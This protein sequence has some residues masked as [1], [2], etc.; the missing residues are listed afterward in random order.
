MLM[1]VALYRWSQTRQP[2][3][4]LLLI[5]IALEL[6]AMYFQHVMM[7]APCVMCI[8]E[9]VAMVGMGL[10]AAI[11]LIAPKNPIVRW[12]GLGV[13]GYSSVRSWQLANEHVGYQFPDPNDLFGAQCDIFVNFP[14]WAPLNEWVPWFFEATGDCS[15]IV[16]QFMD[17]SMPQWLEIIS[18]LN[19]GAFAIIVLS[20]IIGMVKHRG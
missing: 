20:Q 15:K 14:D 9:R 11:G 8:Y 5:I 2:W 7:L 17:L 3:L 1:F 10:G 4:I 12:L 13:W 18:A 16:W 19:I 6:A